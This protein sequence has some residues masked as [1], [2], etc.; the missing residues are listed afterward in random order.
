M[1]LR[2]IKGFVRTF[3]SPR[4]LYEEI[5]AG[6]QNPSWFCVLIYCLIYV[7]G[8]LWL[9]FKGFTPFVDPWIKLPLESYY[10]VQSFY[11][12][13]LVFL[14]WILGTGVLHIA[15]KF[16]GGNGR[17]DVLLVMTGYSLWA[18][19]YP[20]I[21]VDF[22]HATPEWLYYTVLGICIILLL[23][24]TT[25]ALMVEEKIRP[26]GAFASSLIAFISTGLILFTYIR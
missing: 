19:W 26:A 20:L 24:V 17:F 18:P 1:L 11:I 9:Y 16:F 3:Y 7:G 23:A 21:I 25:L 12:I 8:S 5:S 15:G 4:S 6:E 2:F 14:M 13:P 10:L 22:I